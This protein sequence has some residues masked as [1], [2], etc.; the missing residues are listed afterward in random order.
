MKESA[1]SKDS[2]LADKIASPLDRL[3][4]IADLGCEVLTPPSVELGQ[5]QD[6]DG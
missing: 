3:G 4:F 5:R 1:A 2:V 6:A